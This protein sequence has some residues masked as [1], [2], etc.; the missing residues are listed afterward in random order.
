[1]MLPGL[2][3]GEIIIEL[4]K[5]DPNLPIIAMSGVMDEEALKKL[6]IAGPP[7]RP[8]SKPLTAAMLMAAIRESRS[9]A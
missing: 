9:G 6:P 1:M 8:L 2:S 4:R 3:G 5:R 7:V